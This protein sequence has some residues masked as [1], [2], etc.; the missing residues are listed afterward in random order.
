MVELI[1]FTSTLTIQSKL[2]I[3]NVKRQLIACS[4]HGMITPLILAPLIT[5]VLCSMELVSQM[6]QLLLILLCIVT[7]I[8]SR[9]HWLLLT[10][11]PIT[12]YGPA[13]LPR[14][15]L[16]NQDMLARLPVKMLN[17]AIHWLMKTSLVIN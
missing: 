3:K 1:I 9:N 4:L 2:V 8:S 14:L 6:D 12:E 13:M 10:N 11:V 17:I 16:V 7:V 15:L 5:N